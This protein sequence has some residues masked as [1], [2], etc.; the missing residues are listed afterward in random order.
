MRYDPTKHHRRSI[1]MSGYDYA[2]EGAYFVTV[3]T[4]QRECLFGGIADGEMRID[5]YGEVVRDEWLRSVQIRR[6]IDLDVFVVMPNHLHGIVVIRD[7]GAHGRAP[8]PP[9][10]PPPP[11][12]LGSVVAGVKSAGPRRI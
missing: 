11:R 2:E 6:E 12:S 10:P 5:R 1:R 4:H 9:A 7:V 8:L 3:V